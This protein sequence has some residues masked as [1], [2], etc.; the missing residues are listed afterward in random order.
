[1]KKFIP[2]AA[3]SLINASRI[4]E[5]INIENQ[6]NINNPLKNMSVD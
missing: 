5:E 3:C 4:N 1:M 6:E 2:L